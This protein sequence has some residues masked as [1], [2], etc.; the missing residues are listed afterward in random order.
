MVGAEAMAQ[1]LRADV[2][3]G[4]GQS[5]SPVARSDTRKLMQFDPQD[6]FDGGGKGEHGLW[7]R[8]DRGACVFVETPHG[9][10][11]ILDD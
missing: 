10:H 5:L 7:H 8:G 9:F 11:R 1:D 2:R 4:E 3:F 6:G